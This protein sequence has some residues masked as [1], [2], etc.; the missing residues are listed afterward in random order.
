MV[1]EGEG[2]EDDKRER[3]EEE[4]EKMG[5]NRDVTLDKRKRRQHVETVFNCFR[6]MYH[7]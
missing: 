1:G 4:E 5:D 7:S 3:E 2:D 6:Y